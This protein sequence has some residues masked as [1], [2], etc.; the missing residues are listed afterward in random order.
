V[1]RPR[2]GVTAKPTGTAMRSRAS[3]RTE[4]SPR[5]SATGGTRGRGTQ[6][7][8]LLAWRS[9]RA[10]AAL[11]TIP[12]E[13]GAARRPADCRCVH[14][15]RRAGERAS[16]CGPRWDPAARKHSAGSS[17]SAVRTSVSDT[18]LWGDVRSSAAGPMQLWA[19]GRRCCSSAAARIFAPSTLSLPRLPSVCWPRG[20]RLRRP[21]RGVELRRRS[22]RR[23]RVG[24]AAIAIVRRM[25]GLR[26]AAGSR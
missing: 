10:V 1:S 12:F 6:P 20:R 11:V 4:Q 25:R 17:K 5:A 15:R 23:L 3:V 24:S 19:P 18:E 14:R 13:Q 21:S 2:I 26:A 8:L 16:A 7:R 22:A 9:A